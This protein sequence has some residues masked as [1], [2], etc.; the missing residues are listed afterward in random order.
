MNDTSDDDVS[1]MS[2]EKSDNDDDD[3]DNLPVSNIHAEAFPMDSKS[4]YTKLHVAIRRTRRKKKAW[5]P[6]KNHY[7]AMMTFLRKKTKMNYLIRIM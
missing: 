4:H 3:D 7:A 6:R 2:D 1:D 5:A